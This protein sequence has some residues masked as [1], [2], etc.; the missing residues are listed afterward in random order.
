MDK[1]RYSLFVLFH[2]L[3]IKLYFTEY[4][5]SRASVYH[6]RNC[7]SV[8]KYTVCISSRDQAQRPRGY[9][10]SAKARHHHRENVP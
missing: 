7:V 9:D 2:F 5:N 3:L 4:G 6:I 1:T 8:V 10:S